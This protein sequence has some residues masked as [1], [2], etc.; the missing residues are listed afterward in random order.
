MRRAVFIILAIVFLALFYVGK[1][2]LVDRPGAN[3]APTPET[4]EQFTRIVSTAPSITEVL[5]ALGAA[6]RV[7]GVTEYCTYPPE[8][9]QK[10]I[11]GGYLD[12]VGN[13]E[14]LVAARPDLIVLTAG[15]E[16]EKLTAVFR[17]N[18]F[19]T[20]SVNHNSVEGILDSIRVLGRHTGTI[21]ASVQLISEHRARIDAI[22]R[23]LGQKAGNAARPRV[24]LSVG[25]TPGPGGFREIYAAGVATFYH[26]VLE[27]A[28]GKN[29]CPN[30][31]A[32][33][34][35]LSPE[36]IYSVEP[37]VIVDLLPAP[38]SGVTEEQSRSEWQALEGLKAVR[39][40][41]LLIVKSDYATIPGPRIVLL[42]EELARKMHPGITLDSQ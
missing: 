10:Q 15:Q 19:S 33:Y 18:S 14:G 6:D 16:H 40:G 2:T 22:G 12:L 32:R 28:G 8:A 21:D 36:E 20:V 25:R 1:Q 9:R 31:T 30:T 34:P 39:D 35:R 38:E 3:D 37:D 42:I 41:R 24:L 7:V 26:D 27:L 4:S 11:I 13:L 23:A 5:F 29:A 17:E